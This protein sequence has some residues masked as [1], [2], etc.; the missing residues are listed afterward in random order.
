[1]KRLEGAI[2]ALGL[3]ALALTLACSEPERPHIV[4]LL[5][6]TLRSDHLGTYGYERATTPFIDELAE[7]GTVFESVVAQAPW[8]TPSMASIWT[9][10][11]PSQ[12]GVGAPQKPNGVRHLEAGAPTGLAS[13]V[14]TLAALL[15][16]RGYA[17]FAV[18]PNKLASDK[19][20][21][22]RGFETRDERPGNAGH[23]VKRAIDQLDSH[24]AAQSPPTQP[25]L[26]YL[27]FMDVHEP[28]HPPK[29]FD[30]MFPT[31]DGKPHAK[32]HF[33]WAF[34]ILGDHQKPGFPA[35]RSHKIALYD[36]SLAFIDSHI[37]RLVEALE[38]RALLENSVLVIASDH[39]EDLWDHPDF[40]EKFAHNPYR[41]G[42]AGHGHSML[43]EVLD[44]P[45]IF[46]GKGVPR[47]R[48]RSQ[49]RNIDIMPTLLGLAG[50]HVRS[51]QLE[52]A[53]LFAADRLPEPPELFSFS[54][55]IGYGYEAKVVSDGRFKYIRYT[56]DPDTPEF[57]F[58]RMR[59][60]DEREDLSA[61]QPRLLSSLRA[62]MEE[63]IEANGRGTGKSVVLTPEDIEN[64]RAL[65][66]VK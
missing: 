44:V 45:L 57:L 15:A 33:G 22:L 59:D 43:G 19:F 52:G 14:P 62:T 26:L 3:S 11:Y 30:T 49:V 56:G 38:S 54:E 23:V 9:S 21:L 17:T 50:I 29:P 31:L 63:I 32:E 37:R 8:T 51:L 6:D 47:L 4:L 65:G 7:E 5:I 18:T 42:G 58:D 41:E 24:L 46:H 27:H 25:L 10:K 55:D 66:Y 61:S 13:D 20:G 28:T 12:L 16:E 64:L 39:G 53:D 48:V 35:Y 1:M 34:E 40:I 60:P 36:G 2:A